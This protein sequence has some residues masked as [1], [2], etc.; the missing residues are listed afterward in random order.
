MKKYLFKI[1][2]FVFII[3]AAS[4]LH[5]QRISA[6]DF[7]NQR[8]TDILMALAEMGGRSV[9]V[10]DTVTGTATFYFSDMEFEEALSQFLEACYLFYRKIDNNYY[11]S[12]IFVDY[13]IDTEILN[14]F[15][16]DANIEAIVR[17]LSRIT[18]TT[19]IYDA[20][21]RDTISIRSLDTSIPDILDILIRRYPDFSI[22]YINN[23]YYMRRAA[24]VGAASSSRLA[25]NAITRR[26]DLYSMNIPRGAFSAI[27]ALLFRTAGKEYSMLQRVDS[28]IENL[29]FT[30][31]T[32]EELLRLVLEQGNCDYA[33]IGSIYYIFEIQR[34][35]VLKKLKDTI[36]V[37]MQNISVMDVGALLP[38]EL[39][40]SSFIKYNANTNS[41]YLTGSQEEINPILDFLALI[42]VAVEGRYYNRFE[43]KH[44][45]VK[46]F[47]A[48]LPRELASSSP[49]IIPNSNAFIALI[50]DELKLRMKDYIRLVDKR[51][52]GFPVYL[53]YIKSEELLRFLPPSVSREE[54][55][56]SADPTLI[57]FTGAKEKKQYFLDDLKLIDKPK[58]QIRY[59]L[60]I[61]QYQKSDSLTL[62]NKSSFGQSDL[63]PQRTLSGAFSNLLN[64]NFDIVYKFGYQLAL[65]LNMQIG[66]NKARVLA[67]TTLNGIS[68]QDI[69]FE[70]KNTFRYRDVALDPETGRP[71][72]TGITREITSGLFLNINGWVSGDG[73]ITMTVRADISKQ[74]DNGQVTT[75]AMNPPPTSERVVNTQV[76]TKSGTPIII[77]GLLQVEKT[78][79]HYNFPVLGSV[80]LLGRLF[81][82]TTISEETTEMV[83][84]IV[85]FIQR[86]TDSFFDFE[87]RNEEYF[88]RYILRRTS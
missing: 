15:A 20:L 22:E 11:V 6:I 19:I 9:I 13:S 55:V 38:N 16:E 77:G 85:P 41:I 1:A 31:K 57:F 32:F 5:A 51:P 74:A 58:P 36:V 75:T 50:S 47:I 78:E 80:P 71:L 7:R 37:Q 59:Q 29:Y 69:R 42:D 26:G 48:L 54:V 61:I 34:R 2:V 56:V 62:G 33:K 86:S 70:N 66:E 87:K 14:V 53:R 52:H 46:D 60:L 76:R 28:N 39:G 88:N 49:V 8:I 21:P 45:N 84:Y 4:P 23:S 18:N 30:D 82:N 83:I 67:D 73:M 68:G 72:Y 43:I 10:D 40:A 79:A 3:V 24:G 17:E 27:L 64:I 12:R 35:D 44:L 25:G 65:Q 81:R 63:D